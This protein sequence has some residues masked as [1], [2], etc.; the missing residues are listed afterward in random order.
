MH[1][2]WDSSPLLSRATFP[3]LTIL[4]WILLFLVLFL[5][6]LLLE[7][8]LWVLVLILKDFHPLE[9]EICKWEKS[10]PYRLKKK[11]IRVDHFCVWFKLI[12]NSLFLSW[13]LERQEPDSAFTP[14]NWLS[15]RMSPEQMETHQP[16]YTEEICNITSLLFLS[17]K[18]SYTSEC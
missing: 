2:N 3:A 4:T 10:T 15:I 17:S 9:S 8:C 1:T 6:S 18:Y 11:K 16:F 12:N 7:S 13:F 5:K 14:H